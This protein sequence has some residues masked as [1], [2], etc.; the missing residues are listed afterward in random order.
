VRLQQL[1]CVA[2]INNLL[3]HALCQLLLDAL[4]LQANGD[5]SSNGF[6]TE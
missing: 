6:H 1:A 2:G 4:S 3:V 5:D